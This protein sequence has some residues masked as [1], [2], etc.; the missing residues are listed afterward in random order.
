MAR[1]RLYGTPHK[2]L[3]HALNL[4]VSLAGRLHYDVKAEVDELKK[5]GHDLFMLLDEHAANEEGYLLKPLEERCPG[6]GHD[7]HQEHELIEKEQAHLAQ[8]LKNLDGKQDQEVGHLF[9]LQASAFQAYYLE[10]IYKEET[11]TEPL[12]QKYFTDEE[13]LRLDEVLRKETFKD[14]KRSFLL[15]P[16]WL[17]YIVPETS[18]RENIMMLKQLKGGLPVP[19]FDAICVAIKTSINEKQYNSLM[20]KI[21]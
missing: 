7:N 5:I 4:F 20:G 21:G 2:G 9:Y 18:E 17:K 1:V 6:G 19:L 14:E 16:L 8:S 12:L 10:H 11:V 3:R 15:L 13:L